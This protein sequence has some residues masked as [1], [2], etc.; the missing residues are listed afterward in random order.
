MRVADDGCGIYRDDI[1]VAF[2]R[3]ATSKVKVESD[4][5]SISTL[6]FRERLLR[7]F[8]QYHDFNLLREM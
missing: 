2:L 4:L 3:H 5:D 8:V 7:Q 1:K 6:G